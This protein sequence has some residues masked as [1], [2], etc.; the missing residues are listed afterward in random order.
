MTKGSKNSSH[1][2]YI[3]WIRTWAGIFRIHDI[4]RC[5]KTSETGAYSGTTQHAI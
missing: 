4:T 2:R 3:Q 5:F 1:Y